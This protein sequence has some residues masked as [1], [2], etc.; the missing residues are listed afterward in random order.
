M[1]LSETLFINPDEIG[2]VQV[3]FLMLV[4]GYILSQSSALISD[5]SELLLLIP[6]LAGIVG[7]VVLPVLGAVPDGAIVLFSGM[8]TPTEVDAQISVGVGALAGSTIMLLTI[9]WALCIISGRVD[10]VNGEAN[11]KGKPKLTRGY[12]LQHTGVT[13][14]PSV[15]VNAKIMIGTAISYVII[16]AAA[17]GSRCGRTVDTDVSEANDCMKSHEH[18]VALVA[19]LFSIACFVGYLYY[20]IKNADSEDN[21]DFIGEVKKQAIE[22]HMISISAAFESDLKTKYGESDKLKHDDSQFKSALKSFFSK[23][24]RD[25]N[26]VIDAYELRVLLDDLNEDMT[27]ERFATFLKEIDTDGSGTVSFKEF[28]VAMKEYIRRKNENPEG[29]S[30]PLSIQSHDETAKHHKEGEAE[31][32]E[33]EEEEEI[34]ED[35]AALPAHQ[36][37]LRILLRSAWMMGVGTVIVLIFSDPMVD[38]LNTVGKRFHIGA[39]YVAFVLAPVASNASELIASI[40]YATKKT[41]KTITIS[42]A[43]LEG[44]ACMNNTFCLAIFLVL[45]FAKGLA[46]KFSAETIAILF[47]E[48]ALFGIGAFI[49]TQKLYLAGVIFSLYP[50]SIF[51]VWFLENVCG[52]N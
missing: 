24:D 11:Y 12:D 38:V 23:Y 52:L 8:G 42:L 5:G 43:A 40:A 6:S 50:L 32:E 2:T 48:L 41:K 30:I 36:Q 45:I 3:I 22:S 25:G 14:R 46:W 37:K 34:P 19:L 49:R 39:F 18:W 13:P 51:L 29:H 1:G 4:Y 26:G 35:I 16:Q 10:L 7:S 44:A 21:E 31:E 9:P 27:E 47:V 28:E 33:E 15:A 17:F 20:N